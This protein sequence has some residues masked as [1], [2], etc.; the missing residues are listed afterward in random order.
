MILRVGAWAESAPS[1]QVLEGDR[2]TSTPY[3]LKFLKDVDNA[4]LCSKT[5]SPEDMKKFGSAVNVD[6]YFQ[7]WGMGAHMGRC[8]DVN[9]DYY[10]QVWGV[11]AHIGRCQVLVGGTW[12]AVMELHKQ[13]PLSSSPLGA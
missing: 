13:L 7:V 8:R 2:L 12:K 10:F 1:L 3:E 11:G 4:V 6:Y 9:L 5:L